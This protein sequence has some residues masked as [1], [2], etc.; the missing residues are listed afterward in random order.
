MVVGDHPLN[1]STKALLGEAMVNAANHSGA[2]RISLYFEVDEDQLAVY[3]TDQSK[4]F[5]VG[6]I[7]G[8]R[9]GIAESIKAP[10]GAGRRRG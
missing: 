3:V 1:E 2:E 10:G 7:G 8:D 9:K 5:V 4:G 6:T